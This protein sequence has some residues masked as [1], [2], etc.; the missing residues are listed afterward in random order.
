MTASTKSEP[1]LLFFA[2]SVRKNSHNKRLARLAAQIAEAN[3]ISSTFID[4]AD[5]PMPLYDGDLE[6]AS[7]QPENAH[8]LK[9]LMQAHTGIFIVSPEYNAAFTPLLKNTLDW[10]SHVR[11]EGEAPLEVYRTRVFALAAASPGG[12]GGLRGLSLLRL[13]LETGIGALVLPDQFLLPRAVDAFDEHGHLK[14]KDQQEQLKKV[15]QKLAHAARV[16]HG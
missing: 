2:G 7:G 15:I 3:N 10:V 5:Y 12:T 9:S 4:L 16:L 6:A 8:K 13:V 14:N 1:R 11:D